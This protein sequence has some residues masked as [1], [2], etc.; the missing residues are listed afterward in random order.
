MKMYNI[1]FSK[2]KKKYNILLVGKI[3]MVLLEKLKE[4]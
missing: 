3:E 2:K 1:F 4:S